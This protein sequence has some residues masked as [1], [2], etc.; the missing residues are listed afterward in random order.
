MR[1]PSNLQ[2]PPTRQPTPQFSC[3]RSIADFSKLI[4]EFLS[5]IENA[6]YTPYTVSRAQKDYESIVVALA[7][8]QKGMEEKDMLHVSDK[9][10]GETVESLLT[11]AVTEK[12]KVDEEFQRISTAAAAA[13]RLQLP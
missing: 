12:G 2:P 4:D 5:R 8:V 3:V 7:V 9:D 11:K 10:Q 6:L 1:A 13:A